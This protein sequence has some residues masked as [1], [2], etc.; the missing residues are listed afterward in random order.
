MPLLPRTELRGKGIDE[1][2][3]EDVLVVTV[4][5]H[6][7]T[8]ESRLDILE[9]NIEIMASAAQAIELGGLPRI[10]IVVSNPL[11][12]LTEYLCRRWAGRPVS[13]MGSGTSL[14]T[15]RFQELL[16]QECNVHPRSVHAWVVGEHG[17][18]SVFL[19]SAAMIGAL[20][21]VDY[22]EQRAIDLSPEW[23]ARIEGDVRSAAYRVRELKGSARHGIAIA[24]SGLVRCFGRETGSLIP[25]SVRVAED[26]CASLPC[27]LGSDGPSAPLWPRMN[28]EQST[29]NR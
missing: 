20:P 25:V 26:V 18:S 6:T 29:R 12:V 4:G 24:V 23:F 16:A 5:H 22:A 27:A 21:L 17:D 10:A 2:E 28:A 15:L 1:I 14:D 9:H 19:F 8:G 3:S 7:K 13:V 11:D